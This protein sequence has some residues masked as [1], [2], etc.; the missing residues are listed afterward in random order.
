MASLYGRAMGGGTFLGSPYPFH[1]YLFI[2]RTFIYVHIHKTRSS[3][4]EFMIKKIGSNGG[5]E[6]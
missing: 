3:T 1:F 4:S 6:T 2:S 5:R